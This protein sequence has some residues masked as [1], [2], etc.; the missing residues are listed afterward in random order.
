MDPRILDYNDENLL[1]NHT[2]ICSL[3]LWFIFEYYN[4]NINWIFYT[5]G[6]GCPIAI[7]GG[8]FGNILAFVVLVRGRLW[9]KHEGY[10]YLAANFC[11]NVGI[12]LFRTTSFW[13]MSSNEWVHY[14]PPNTS[15]FMC[16]VWYFLMSIFCASGWLC[17]ALQ[18]NVYFRQT[19]GQG[20]KYECPMFAAKY[21]TLF[22]SKII[23]AVIF[24]ILFVLGVP[25]L[26]LFEFHSEGL[27]HSSNHMFS[28]LALLAEAIVM[29]VLPFV[30]FL[31]VIL[32]IT[33][34]TKRV[35]NTV[36]ISQIENRFASDDAMRAVAVTQSSMM[37]VS[38][39]V[40]GFCRRILSSHLVTLVVLEMFYSLSIALQPVLCFIIL[41]PLR[42]GFRSQLRNIRCCRR[43]FP[44]L[45]QEEEAIQLREEA[46]QLRANQVDPPN[47][48]ES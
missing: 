41:K 1:H 11:V 28:H 6:I 45:N 32:L 25:N 30:C 21:C 20:R 3:D 24:S 42:E 29:L 37:L 17:V 33:L 7:L 26:V 39:H 5:V 27:C 31:P 46:A 13:I 34:L 14:Y 19:L 16:K 36:G 4:V 8:V 10:V 40:M 18:F 35:S 23:V 2:V 43:L 9:L 15:T 22:A 38:M 12:L 47:T 44:S 48:T